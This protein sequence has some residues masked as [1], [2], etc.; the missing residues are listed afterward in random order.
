MQLANEINCR[1]IGQRE[2]NVFERF[3]HNWWFIGVI[4]AFS[5]MQYFQIQ[6]FWWLTRTHTMKTSEWG[7]CIVVGMTPLVISLLL[8]MTP[9]AW[10]AHIPA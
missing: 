6:W 4:I 5:V 1:K 8:K 9:S 10:L 3:F 2:F 7:G